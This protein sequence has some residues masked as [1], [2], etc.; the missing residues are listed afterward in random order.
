[1]DYDFII[2]GA[3]IAGLYSAL[4]ITTAFPKARVALIEMD[5]FLGGRIQTYH[6]GTVQFEKGAGRIHSSHA[7]VN[8]LVAHYGLTKIKIPSEE[9]AEWH[10]MSTQVTKNMWSSL[11]TYIVS[12]LHKLEK[13]ILQTH[14][15]EQILYSTMDGQKAKTMLNRFAYTSELNT[16]RADIA[17]ESLSNELGG[18]QGYFYVV[19]EGLGSIVD[20]M[21]QDLKGKV[22]IFTEHRLVSLTTKDKVNLNFTQGKNKVQKTFKATKAI[23]AIH[24]D[25]LKGIAL[26]KNLPILKHLSMTPLLRIYGVFPKPAWF[27]DIPRTITDSPLRNVIPISAASGTIMTSYTD[28]KD[29]KFWM[30]ILKNEGEKAVSDRIISESEKLFNR[31]IPKPTFFKMCHWKHGCSYWLPG[32]YDVREESRRIMQPIPLAHPNIFVC[33]E[34]YAVNQAWIESALSHADDMLQRFILV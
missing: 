13:S 6:K 30:D 15:L 26:F 34:S 20:H 7:L 8:S 32:L 2:V 19:K 3:G 25:A 17:L 4:K 27:A 33:G 28:N 14:T 24:S 18:R 5:K 22:D 11:A 1:M 31:S 12:I 23:L 21:V 10:P 29:T 16:L 9:V